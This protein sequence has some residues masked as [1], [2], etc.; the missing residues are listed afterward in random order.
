MQK[1]AGYAV[2]HMSNGDAR[3]SHQQPMKRYILLGRLDLFC[4][5]QSVEAGIRNV[6]MKPNKAF[7][8]LIIL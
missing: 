8:L 1:P 4:D 2:R 3:M 5:Q 7:G 6:S